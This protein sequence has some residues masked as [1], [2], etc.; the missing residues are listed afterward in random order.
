MQE[1]V[2]VPGE[3]YRYRVER[4]FHMGK[5]SRQL[6][7]GTVVE[8]DGQT[9]RL[10]GE[11]HLVPE[12]RSAIRASWLSRQSP[13]GGI[14]KGSG[15]K[16]PP[17]PPPSEPSPGAVSTKAAGIKVR[18]ATVNGGRTR[19][20][21]MLTK[22][23]DQ[24][25]VGS[26]ARP[27][28]AR[29]EPKKFNPTLIRENEGNQHEVGRAVNASRHTEAG[30]NRGVERVAVATNF[31]TATK[32]SILLDGGSTHGPE[33]P[34]GVR[35]DAPRANLKLKG[36]G[37]SQVV[38]RAGKIPAK[39]DRV[40]VDSESAARAAA[41]QVERPRSAAPVKARIASVG[42]DISSAESDQLEEILPALDP[43][44]RA[45]MVARQRR[46]QAQKA[47]EVKPAPKPEAKKPG[48]KPKVSPA[49]LKA[50]FK[51]PPAPPPHAVE[52][53]LTAPVGVE[54]APG[55]VWDKTAHWSTRVKLATQYRDQPEILEAICQ[56]ESEGV[57]KAIRKALESKVPAVTS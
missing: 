13:V 50:A 16:A 21:P 23:D 43:E 10:S 4:E 18:P 39:V 30:G 11:E 22:T 7:L 44:S 38:G 56:Y 52:A 37:D 2:Y 29:N 42:D 55:V 47:A 1:F 33:V 26:V 20:D 53:H 41:A 46:E 25:V 49:P 57:V 34:D 15:S 9:L 35:A 3:F 19:E 40:L 32:S 8:Y 17:P 14:R 31:R 48:P 51:T 27:A 6:A 28:P 45:E 36:E 54:V 5:L 24:V 12:L